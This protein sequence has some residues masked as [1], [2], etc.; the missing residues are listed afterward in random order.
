MKILPHTILNFFGVCCNVSLFYFWLCQLGFSLSISWVKDL[1]VLFISKSQPSDLLMLCTVSASL[2]SVLLLII[3]WCWLDLDFFSS[4]FWVYH[5]SYLFVLFLTIYF[6]FFIYL[7]FLV[8]TRAPQIFLT[9]CRHFGELKISLIGNH[10][11]C[12]PN[13]LEFCFGFSFWFISW[14][15]FIFW[16]HSS[17]NHELLNFFYLL[18]VCFLSVLSF[19][20]LLWYKMQAVT[21][22]CL[23]L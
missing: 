18:D 14:K 20:P 22:F 3:S 8:I 23:N 4:V 19:I 12:I 2:I 10:F 17:F 5:L 21:S 15:F 13:V 7:C 16:T 6:N 11:Q 1:S 9:L